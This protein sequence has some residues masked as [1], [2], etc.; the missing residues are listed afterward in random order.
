MEKTRFTTPK[1]RITLDL[2]VK[3]LEEQLLKLS[4]RLV[5][6][7][8]AIMQLMHVANANAKTAGFEEMPFVGLEPIEAM[9]PTN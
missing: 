8:T 1:E 6:A 3:N 7:N 2:R 5:D 4:E 9:K